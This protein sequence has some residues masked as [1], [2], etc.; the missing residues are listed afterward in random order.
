[1]CGGKRVIIKKRRLQNF[2]EKQI[3]EKLRVK[4]L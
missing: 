2:L 3:A 4:Y 1:M